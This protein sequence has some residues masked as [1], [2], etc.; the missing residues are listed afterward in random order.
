MPFEQLKHVL[1][2]NR[3][4]SVVIFPRVFHLIRPFFR[5]EDTPFFLTCLPTTISYTPT[6]WLPSLGLFGFWVMIRH[7]VGVRK[8]PIAIGFECHAL[9]HRMKDSPLLKILQTFQKTLLTN[10]MAN[11]FFCQRWKR[12]HLLVPRSK[13]ARNTSYCPKLHPAPLG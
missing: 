13:A 7:M 3:K 5:D 2:R 12:T 8:R 6:F 9:S 10:E 1:R 11:V 4:D